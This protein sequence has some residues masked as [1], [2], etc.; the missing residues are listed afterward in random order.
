MINKIWFSSCTGQVIR[1]AHKPRLCGRNE[2]A[3]RWPRDLQRASA[4]RQHFLSN[5]FS[6]T[7]N[8]LCG[9]G[10]I[11]MDARVFSSEEPR[12]K[13]PRLPNI[14]C[15][16]YKQHVPLWRVTVNPHIPDQWDRQLREP[17]TLNSTLQV[18]RFFSLIWVK[19]QV[20]TGGTLKLPR[21]FTHRTS[22]WASVGDLEPGH[23][24]PGFWRVA[25]TLRWLID[26]FSLLIRHCF[27]YVMK[28]PN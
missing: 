28:F 20:Q 1:R 14:F 12:Y 3:E 11:M 25:E 22:M 6:G 10:V 2:A 7:Q 23:C 5:W 13:F 8:V 15:W 24:T 16:S 17:W 27:D 21:T 26:S 4:S 9:L 19:G 18:T